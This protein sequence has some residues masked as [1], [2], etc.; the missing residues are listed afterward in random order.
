M[1][2]S[3]HPRFAM[4]AFQIFISSS[5][6]LRPCWK[7]HSKISSSEPPSSVQILKIWNAFITP[8]TLRDE[9]IPNLYLLFARPAPVLETPLQ[10]L[11]VRTTFE[12]SDLKDLECVH[13][14][15]HASR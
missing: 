4:N 15:T 1:R 2:S 7:H 3:R 13:H 9:R 14:A 10:N 12:R 11:F 5:L 8:P 6:G